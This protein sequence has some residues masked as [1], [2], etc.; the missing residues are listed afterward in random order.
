[1]TAVL[2]EAELKD[3][4]ECVYVNVHVKVHVNAHEIGST[5]IPPE[6]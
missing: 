1:M 2:G 4:L 5:G 3:P 6:V